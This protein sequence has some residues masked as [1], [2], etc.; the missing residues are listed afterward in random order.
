[1]RAIVTCLMRAIVTR[2]MWAIVT[3]LIEAGEYSSSF[4][5]IKV[6]AFRNARPRIMG[7]SAA[8]YGHILWQEWICF[9][10]LHP[11]NHTYPDILHSAVMFEFV[12]L[13]WLESIVHL[14]V[15]ASSCAIGIDVWVILVAV[16]DGF[17]IKILSNSL[18]LACSRD[19]PLLVPVM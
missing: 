16:A 9:P 17:D 2:L 1:M 12:K 18:S 3:S 14:R 8:P 4:S 6:G 19:Y 11:T 7:L 5:R 13:I 10:F 15:Y